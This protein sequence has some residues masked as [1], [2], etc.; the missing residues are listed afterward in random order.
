MTGM[1]AL[2]PFERLDA[3]DRNPSFV[4]QIDVRN[5][6]LGTGIGALNIRVFP[7]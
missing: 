7:V 3:R 1:G 6:K 2:E 4:E 5:S